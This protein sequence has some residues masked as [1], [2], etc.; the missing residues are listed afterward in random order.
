MSAADAA[1]GWR[2]EQTFL[3]I[4][5]EMATVAALRGNFSSHED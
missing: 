1:T 5:T 4:S 3:A 2:A